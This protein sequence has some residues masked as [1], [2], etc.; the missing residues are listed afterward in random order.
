MTPQDQIA[1][2][3]AIKARL[4]MKAPNPPVV[5]K[6]REALQAEIAQKA[7]EQEDFLKKQIRE[8]ALRIKGIGDYMS[9]RRAMLVLP[10]LEKHNVTWA[11]VLSSTRVQNV[12]DCRHEIMATLREDGLSY[13]Q[14]GKALGGRDHSTVMHGV[15]RFLG[16]DYAVGIT[17]VE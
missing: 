11:Q 3:A 8:A 13:P 7:L 15:R 9:K 6:S 2:Y 5:R 4:G 12:V 10:V 17:V 16:K 1:H 14:I